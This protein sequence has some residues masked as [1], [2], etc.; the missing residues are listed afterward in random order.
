MIRLNLNIGELRNTEFAHR[1]RALELKRRTQRDRLQ[2]SEN[3]R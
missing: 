3:N 2:K 1:S